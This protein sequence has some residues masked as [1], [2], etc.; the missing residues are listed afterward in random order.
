MESMKSMQTLC[1]MY[2][3]SRVP[4]GLNF[5]SQFI[6]ETDHI[7]DAGCGTGNYIQKLAPFAKN[8]TGIDSNEDVLQWAKSKLGGMSNVNLLQCSLTTKLP[9]ENATFDVVLVNQVLQYL[10]VDNENYPNV[11]FLLAELRRVLKPGGYILINTCSKA[12]VDGYWYINLSPNCREIFLKEYMS[13]DKLAEF[14]IEAGY[15]PTIHG[16]NILEP[17]QGMKYFNLLGPIDNIWKFGSNLEYGNMDSIRQS[18]STLLNEGRLGAY[19]DENDK[20]RRENGQTIYII[21]RNVETENNETK[22]TKEPKVI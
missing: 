10:D 11:R 5:I 19:F 16:Q 21:G 3:Y 6:K 13:L 15:N 18:L 9:F 14:M 7:L 17:L 12:M 22:E 1:Q 8:M 4:V 2:D 20:F